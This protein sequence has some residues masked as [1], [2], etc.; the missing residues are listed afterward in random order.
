MRSPLNFISRK[1]LYNKP[2]IINDPFVRVLGYNLEIST[3]K[4]K[5]ALLSYLS[6]PVLDEIN[7]GSSVRFSN[8][9]LATS[10][11]KILNRIGYI[12]DIINWDDTDFAFNDNYDLVI[13][14]GGI[15]FENISKQLK[16]TT[17]YIYFSTGSYWKFHNEQEKNRFREFEIRHGKALPNDRY[18][19]HPEEAANLRAAAIICLGNQA[20]A[21]TYEKF[22]NVYNLPIGSF[23]TKGHAKTLAEIEYGRKNVLFIAGAGNIHKGLDLVLDAVAKLPDIHLYIYTFLD[24][25]FK[26]FYKKQLSGE[27]V[28]IY[29]LEAFPNEKFLELTRKCNIVVMPSC[30]EGSPGSIVEAMIQGLI[31]IVSA[32]AHIDIDNF[33]ALLKD[34]SVETIMKTLLFKVNEDGKKLQEWSRLASITG[35]N[36]HSKEQ[37]EESLLRIMR[38]I[39][40]DK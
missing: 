37:Y 35:L 25:D 28:T 22:D 4:P 14:H 8:D 15:N 39:I 24:D 16:P 11:P 31:P 38:S 20:V 10:W 9:G 18:I 3:S 12:V 30:S 26:Q 19:E 5:R 1:K 36:R 2:R 29:D 32:E 27:Q 21:D 34:N 17:K 33:G 13:S 23:T 40:R 7:G 6:Q